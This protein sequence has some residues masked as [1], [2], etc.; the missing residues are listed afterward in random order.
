MRIRTVLFL[1]LMLP[2]A[3][4]AQQP[5]LEKILVPLAWPGAIPGAFGSLWF[6]QYKA[7]NHAEVPVVILG[8]DYCGGIG[9]CPP[10]PAIAPGTSMLFGFF[11]ANRTFMTID[12]AVA[13]D[14][15]VHLRVLDI[16][17]QSLSW[18][19]EI[20]LI[21]FGD[22][23]RGAIRLLD[24]PLDERFRATLRIYAWDPGAPQQFHVRIYPFQFV[25][26]FPYDVPDKEI[27]SF[28]LIAGPDGFATAG[29]DTITREALRNRPA[30]SMR[31]V[32]TP[33]SDAP[34]WAFI[35]I[36]N[37]ETQQVTLSTPH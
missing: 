8:P 3:L 23:E 6:L 7:T 21:R 2:G 33:D 29:V 37:N 19:T 16:T 28:T 10:P 5:T 9:L 4:S 1:L 15:S 22:T 31:L 27:D 18:G 14:V 32:I 25:P 35:S 13:G 26:P 36:T 20:P 11:Y 12:S 24:V 17:R 34:W 30:G